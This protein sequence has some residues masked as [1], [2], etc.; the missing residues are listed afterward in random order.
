MDTKQYRLDTTA[1][2]GKLLRH[3]PS[4]GGQSEGVKFDNLYQETTLYYAALFK[5]ERPQAIWES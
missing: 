4:M 3:C 2:Y 5:S 1:F